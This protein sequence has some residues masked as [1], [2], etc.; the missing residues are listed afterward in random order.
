MDYVKY[1]SKLI[2]KKDEYTKQDIVSLLKTNDEEAINQLFEYADEVKNEFMGNIL[3]VRAILEFSNY[4]CQNCLY[5]GIRNAN[6]TIKRYRIEPEEI[7]KY[8]L[9]AESMGF[10]TLILQSGEDP[11]YTVEIIENIIRIIKNN[12]NLKLTLSI[13]E[14]SES[15]YRNFKEAGADRF[16]LKHET[17]DP[18]LYRQLHPD[19]K[20]SNRIRCLRD[21]KSLG[22]DTGSGIMVGLP[23]QTFE[24]IANDILLFKMLDIDMIG[25]G[26]YIPHPDTPLERKF[27]EAG[28]YFAPAVGKFDVEELIY[29][30]IAITRIVTKKTHIP[31][32]TGFN[33]LNENNI[34]EK[35]LQRGANVIMLNITESDL[36]E[37][38][39][40]YPAKREL[41]VQNTETL[42]DIRKKF[43][44]YQVI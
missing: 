6:P 15:E 16:L 19:M 5:C 28:G 39:E 37:F 34:R 41:A 20:Y 2:V 25:I 31:A 22:Y 12:T 30:I 29:K 44:E 18:V 36:R 43:S 35:A 23:G 32:T 1:M 42:E 11:Y 14:R 21:L 4:C 17:S 24:S 10:K 27:E 26:P 7:I 8:A 9:K 33:V 3:H 40:I 13:G 38:Y